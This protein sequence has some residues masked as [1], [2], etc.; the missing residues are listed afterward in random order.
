MGTTDRAAAHRAERGGEAA[1]SAALSPL[2]G[3]ALDDLL[4]ELLQR[5]DDVVQDQR[6]LRLL[7]DAVV[8]IAADLSLDSVLSRIVQAASELAEARYAALG[9]LGAG[10][11]HPLRA[12]IHHGISDEQR[13]LIGDLPR[14]HGLLGLI[15]DQR[16]AAAARHRGAP[17]VVRVPR[18]SP[19]H[20]LLPRG[21]DP[22]W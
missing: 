13:D 2:S 3:A 10:T 5:V 20:E 22:H 9:V 8:G 19:G 11:E 18:A 16:A 17:R 14:G 6:R 12:F 21:A 7:L 15:I 1:P 4:R